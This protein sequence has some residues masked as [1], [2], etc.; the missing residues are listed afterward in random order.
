MHDPS[1]TRLK[2]SQCH[3]IRHS[4]SCPPQQGI[5]IPMY[6]SRSDHVKHLHCARDPTIKPVLVC[7]CHLDLTA[8]TVCSCEKY[9]LSYQGGSYRNP[10]RPQKE[11]STA[12]ERMRCVPSIAVP[13][14]Q[15]NK[16]L[17]RGS[18]LSGHRTETHTKDGQRAIT[19]K[20]PREA[21]I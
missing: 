13:R 20:W 21:R 5:Y 2:Q 1:Q 19:G 16:Y 17:T 8:D 7:S 15:G 4:T 10:P 14:K 6:I 9:I 3:N 11:M 18:P 12:Y